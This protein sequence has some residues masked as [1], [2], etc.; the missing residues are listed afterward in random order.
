MK[1]STL[2][3]LC[4]ML[5]ALLFTTEGF[6]QD[7]MSQVDPRAKKHYTAEQI[8]TFSPE[9]LKQVNFYYSKSF[10]LMKKGNGCPDVSE[11]TIDITKYENQR[12]ENRRVVVFIAKPG[13]SIELLS[14]DEMNAEYSKISS[15][16]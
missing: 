9:K 8:N 1:R 10:V 12:A 4:F 6:S 16:K 15:S 11:Q 7:N 2:L 3:F 5:I 14:R 13:C